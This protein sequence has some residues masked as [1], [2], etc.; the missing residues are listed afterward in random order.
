MHDPGNGELVRGIVEGLQAVREDRD[1]GSRFDPITDESEF[2]PATPVPGRSCYRGLG[3]VLEFIATWTAPFDSW[4]VRLDEAIEVD[5]TRVV[6]L[7]YQRG[8]GKGSGVRV[9][10]NFGG[11][12]EFDNGRVVRAQLY[13]DPADALAAA[14]V[15][16]DEPRP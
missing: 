15:Q 11:V 5:E 6:A 8:F 4:T 9:E 12:F 14:G 1:P 2:V 10:L 13:L 16:A 7:M 3:G